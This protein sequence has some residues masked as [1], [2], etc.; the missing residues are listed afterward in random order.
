VLSL[1]PV[2]S[3]DPKLDLAVVIDDSIA[4]SAATRWNELG[5][6]LIA[7]PAGAR[8]AAVTGTIPINNCLNRHP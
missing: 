5:N 2:N 8:V 4:K 1:Q 3:G 7:L 6:F